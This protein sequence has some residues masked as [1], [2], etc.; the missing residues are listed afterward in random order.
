MSN[1]SYTSKGFTCPK[2]NEG[3]G[4]QK[5]RYS[6]PKGI[7]LRRA[8]KEGYRMPRDQ[9]ISIVLAVSQIGAFVTLIFYTI[10]TA[11]MSKTSYLSLEEMKVAR[12]QDTAPH[13]IVYFDVEPN[14]SFIFL[15]IKNVGHSIAED[16]HIKTTPSLRNSS[17]D[18]IGKI[19]VFTKGIKSLSPNTEIR[20]FFDSGPTLFKKQENLDIPLTYNVEIDFSRTDVVSSLQTSSTMKRLTLQT[21]IDLE[22]FRE[23]TY[24]G[25]KGIN[26]LVKETTKAAD[27]LSDIDKK[28][29]AIKDTLNEGIWN[30]EIGLISFDDPDSWVKYLYNQTNYLKY[31]TNPITS[32]DVSDNKRSYFIGLFIETAPKVCSEIAK[33]V[34]CFPGDTHPDIQN[35]T[36]AICTDL[37]ML[38]SVELRTLGGVKS[39]REYVERKGLLPRIDEVL[40]SLRNLIKNTE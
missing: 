24:L 19:S 16:I 29:S 11:K 39:L 25:R 36:V 10:A 37:Q 12:E 18:D 8:G 40:V 23:L 20:T 22:A 38:L 3:F 32:P 6:N 14:S 27:R 34:H 2:N 9:I 7:G 1:E 26:E 17:G 4:K 21:V 5:G 13:I 33:A 31:L 15:V 30:K 35:K 28:L